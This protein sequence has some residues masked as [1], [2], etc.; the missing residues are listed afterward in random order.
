MLPLAAVVRICFVI[1]LVYHLGVNQMPNDE[2]SSRRYSGHHIA[3]KFQ[4]LK[5]KHV[6]PWIQTF[7]FNM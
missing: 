1:L 3:L 7:V 2:S 4:T 6:L 5:K